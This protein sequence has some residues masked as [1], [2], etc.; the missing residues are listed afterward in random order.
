MN[1][2]YLNNPKLIRSANDIIEVA[3]KW[4][5]LKL[6]GSLGVV[7]YPTAYDKL[8]IREFI[9]FNSETFLA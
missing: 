5:E 9:A 6:S 1:I 3:G 4:V 7:Q 2:R 8:V